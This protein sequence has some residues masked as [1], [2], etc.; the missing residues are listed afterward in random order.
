MFK[1]STFW[2]SKL[3]YFLFSSG[4]YIMCEF[5]ASNNMERSNKI[6]ILVPGLTHPPSNGIKVDLK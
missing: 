5:D 4:V 3:R 2:Q 1:N 6:E